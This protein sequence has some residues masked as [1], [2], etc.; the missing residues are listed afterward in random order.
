MN[1]RLLKPSRVSCVAIAI[2]LALLAD[3]HAKEFTLMEATIEDV[4][5]AYKTRQLT[6][7]Q[8]VQMYL[9]RIA[10]Y[11]QKGPRINSVINLNPKAL[12]E[13]DRLDKAFAQSGF[14]GPL[15][16][17][18]ILIKDQADVAGLPTTMGS[19][20]F[21]DFV[22]QKDS[23]AVARLQAAGAIV[24]GKTTLGELGGGDTYGSLFGAT[25]NP[26]D[27][28]RTAG[29]SSGGTAASITA[30]FATV[31]I[32]QEGNSSIRRPSAWTSIVGMRP[33]A[34]LVSR[35]GVWGGWPSIYGSLG[36]MARTVTDLAKVLDA[37][38]G[39]DPEDPL[40]A[41]GVDHLPGKSYTSYLDKDGLKGARIGVI[42][43]TIS[44]NAEPASEDFKKVDAVFN[45]AVAELKAAGAIVI[46]NVVIKDLNPLIAKRAGGQDDSKAIDVYLA[47]NPN[48]P[49]KNREELYTPENLAKVGA[50]KQMGRRSAVSE[51]DSAKHYQS[52]VAR[53]QLMTN[54]LTAMAD[55]KLDAI[56]HKSVE[57]SPTFIKD[58]IN[59][60]YQNHKGVITVNTTTV[61]ASSMSVPAGFTRDNL[62]VGITFLGRPYA[63]GTLLKLAYAY[64][65]ATHHR[66]A[67]ANVPALTK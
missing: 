48:S 44:Y 14:V 64:E 49:Y 39:Y 23:F 27:V 26:Y 65:H 21:K 66:I 5:N 6:A 59:P 41:Y 4:Q 37:M 51:S 24:L 11:D 56:V 10:A 29:G 17:I 33:T 15:H 34:G 61:F 63:E 8:L 53:E 18:P 46:D 22:P 55:N 9:D 45:K 38:V 35:S 40:T 3:A 16:G 54:L 36:P 60:P 2:G 25:R 57:H 7:R 12:E 28:E 31:G 67:P 52:L 58:G 43:E 30:N 42:R 20:L 13:A 47:R 62:P 19:V 50:H 1:V 32:G